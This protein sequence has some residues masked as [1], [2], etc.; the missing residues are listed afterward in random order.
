MTRRLRWLL[1]IV[2][3]CLL[4]Y[5]GAAWW[6]GQQAESV[7]RVWVAEA[8]QRWQ[9]EA[10]APGQAPVLSILDY[11]RGVFSSDL[12][13]RFE[14]PEARGTR[15][16]DL[17]N[18]LQ[19]GPWP[20]QALQEGHWAPL[21]AY[22]VLEPV[23]GPGWQ[24]WFDA[25]PRGV[26]PWILQARI[27]FNGALRASWRFEPAR[28]PDAGFS[29]AG[30][31][32]QVERDA[33]EPEF[34]VRAD[35]PHLTFDDADERVSLEIR[36]LV[37]QSRMILTDGTHLQVHQIMQTG[38]L[39]LVTDAWP[40]LLFEQSELT[41]DTAR[42]GQLVD[43]RLDWDLGRM[44]LQGSDLGR[45]RARGSVAQFNVQAWDALMS[46]METWPEGD[47]QDWSPQQRQA[48]LG[49]LRPVFATGPVLAL[50][51][52]QWQTPEGVSEAALHIGLQPLDEGPEPALESGV[53]RASLQ[54]GVSRPM[55]LYV[56]GQSQKAQQQMAVAL[57]SMLF[58]RLAAHLQ[59]QGLVR[60]ADGLVEVDYHFE[61]G[62]SV[63]NGQSLGAGELQQRIERSA[64]W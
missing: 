42:T 25:M 30:A 18:H 21:A 17:Q 41:M 61:H 45:L 2:A 8:N 13:L 40:G 28:L 51:T 9:L 50:D 31:Q 24:M 60:L 10:S 63:L 64:A 23:A 36:D 39:L 7:L 3:G 37:Y 54:L 35:V 44:Q 11:R 62:Q 56:V 52:L 46:A 53:R 1:C 22:S 32:V 43:T 6:A 47:P 33:G 15:V 48:L 5:T 4:A 38:N 59:R 19:H 27:G 55:V 12:G 57:A 20:W 16:F 58:D 49:L 34:R 29:F 14:Y 26:L